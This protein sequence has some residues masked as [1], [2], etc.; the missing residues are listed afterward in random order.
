MKKI[1][2]I[3]VTL[4]EFDELVSVKVIAKLD[5]LIEHFE[6]KEPT[7]YITRQDV[8][9][10]LCVDISTVHNLTVKGILNKY[11]IGGR[12]LYKRKELDESIVKV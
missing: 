8:A 10:I 6:P 3:D 1:Q 2:L 9:K 11:Q 12:V 4:D 5:K 7:K